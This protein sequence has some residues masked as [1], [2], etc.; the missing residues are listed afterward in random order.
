M[1]VCKELWKPIAVGPNVVGIRV[2]S[3][4]WTFR[5]WAVVTLHRW[6]SCFTRLFIIQIPMNLH[7]F[8]LLTTQ[9]YH[10][11]LPCQ[12]FLGSG[13]Y[14]LQ[15]FNLLILLWWG[16]LLTWLKVLFITWPNFAA[17]TVLL[18]V[19][20]LHFPSQ[21]SL[22]Y[23]SLSLHF[24]YI[25]MAFPPTENLCNFFPNKIFIL[26]CLSFFTFSFLPICPLSLL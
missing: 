16:I 6:H 10:L 21:V 14:P 26:N 12:T 5:P 1:K 8:F 22:A 13:F 2:L 3:Y 17:S 19:S 9:V 25:S 4:I 24:C 7:H 18:H 20:R 23:L 15:N 11:S